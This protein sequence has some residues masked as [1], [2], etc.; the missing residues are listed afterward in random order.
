MT[1]T[2]WRLKT[3]DWGIPAAYPN[4]AHIVG[5]Q[6]CGCEIL[7][8]NCWHS[9]T[10]RMLIA[11]HLCD[12]HAGFASDTALLS[13]QDSHPTDIYLLPMEDKVVLAIQPEFHTR[14]K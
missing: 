10:V 3:F 6:K 8:A 5:T 1:D 13:I 9:P 11:T 4:T 12:E 7:R 14:T 2:H